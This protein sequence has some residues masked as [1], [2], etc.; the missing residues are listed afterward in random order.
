MHG[1]NG[2]FGHQQHQLVEDVGDLHRGREGPLRNVA[3]RPFSAM[4]P[5]KQKSFSEMLHVLGIFMKNL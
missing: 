1:K 5:R 3:Q 2:G 4:I